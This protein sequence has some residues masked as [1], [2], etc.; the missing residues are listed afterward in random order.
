MLSVIYDQLIKSQHSLLIGNASLLF[1]H[2]ITHPSARRFL[3]K[4]PGAEKIIGQMLKL[5]EESWLSR[6]ARKNVAIFITKM[7]KADERYTSQ[8]LISMYICCFCLASW[9]NF[10][11]NM[12][13]KFCIQLLKMLNCDKNF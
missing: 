11:I 8:I 7:V 3:Q 1:G 13:L 2:I 5:V 4:N 9:K 6:A 10:E 12:E